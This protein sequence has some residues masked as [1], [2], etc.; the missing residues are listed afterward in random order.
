MNPY[1]PT[2]IVA[3]ANKHKIKEIK[4]ILGSEFAV[5]DANSLP[6]IPDVIEN[7]NTFKENAAKKAVEFANHVSSL[8]NSG[9]FNCLSF[10]IYVIA[11]DSGLEVDALDGAPGVKSARFASL[12]NNNSACA[13]NNSKLLSLL[14]DTPSER[15]SA[16]FKCIIAILKIA[17]ENFLKHLADKYITDLLP[18]IVYFEGVCEGKI[19]FE[20][21]GNKGFGYDPL[22]YPNGYDKTFA[23][24]GEEVKNKISHRA[25]ALETFAKWLK[26]KKS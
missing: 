20:P 11:D 19:G 26:E 3:S 13:D 6:S 18:S 1:M 21:R 9:K 25:K 7:G 5:L 12:N 4:D 2:I 10:P 14:K 15:R 8:Y 22:F 17:N 23:E 24:L 16:R